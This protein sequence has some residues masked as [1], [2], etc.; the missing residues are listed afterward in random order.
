MLGIASLPN[1]S[2]LMIKPVYVRVH[3]ANSKIFSSAKSGFIAL[4]HSIQ[5][6]IALP[7]GTTGPVKCQKK[8]V[9][10]ILTK[11]LIMESAFARWHIVLPSCLDSVTS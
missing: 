6:T 3:Y 7:V 8:D 9:L 5:R 11:G 2:M 4:M 1:S 10:Y